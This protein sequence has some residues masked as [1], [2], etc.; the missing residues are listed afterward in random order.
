[1]QRIATGDFQSE[2]FLQKPKGE[3]VRK[4]TD[5]YKSQKGE[6]A[7][8]Q[9]IVLAKNAFMFAHDSTAIRSRFSIHTFCFCHSFRPAD[10]TCWNECWHVVVYSRSEEILAL[11][12]PSKTLRREALQLPGEVP[13]FWLLAVS[14][15][16]QM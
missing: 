6:A 15:T 16:H 10:F 12:A 11:I 4:T 8:T 7:S 13:E 9:G 3:S 1:M 2:G 14:K 5:F